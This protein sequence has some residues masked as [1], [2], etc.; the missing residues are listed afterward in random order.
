MGIQKDV[1]VWST[2]DLSSLPVS[3]GNTFTV[4]GTPDPLAF[5]DDI[6]TEDT[7]D[8]RPS[9]FPPEDFDQDL[10]GTLDGAQFWGNTGNQSDTFEFEAAYKVTDGTNTFNVYQIHNVSG[11]T[12]GYVSEQVLDPNAT[13]QVLEVDASVNDDVGDFPSEPYWSDLAGQVDGTS[14]GEVIGAGYVDD[15][16]DGVNEGAGQNDVI[17]GEGGGDTIEAGAGGDLIY[18]DYVEE[19]PADASDYVIQGYV[20]DFNFEMTAGDLE[21]SPTTATIEVSGAPVDIRFVDNDPGLGGDNV[22]D[23]TPADSDQMVEINGVLYSYSADH[24]TEFLG[25]DG[26]TYKMI[27]I[28]VDRDRSGAIDGYDASTDAGDVSYENGQILLPIG[29]VPPPGTTLSPTGADVVDASDPD[30]ISINGEALIPGHDDSISGGADNDTVYGGMGADTIDGGTED[31]SITGGTGAD[32]ITGGDG[33]DQF[34]Y[35]AGDGADTITDFNTGN[36][37]A[38][39]DGDTSNNDYIDLSGF[40]NDTT[41]AEVNALGIDEFGGNLNMLKA[42]AEDG[43]LDGIINGT[44]YSS[45]ISGI[46]LT[47]QNGGA[48]VTGSDLTA[49]NTRVTC[50][51]RGTMIMTEH[52]ERPIETLHQG[53]MILTMDSGYQPIR[54]IG[55]THVSEE[56]LR[57]N[58]NLRPIRIPA[59]ALGNNIPLHDLIV[60]PQHRILIR[61]KIARRMFNRNEVLIA[62]KHLLNGGAIAIANDLKSTQYFHILFDKH[63]LVFSNNAVTESMYTGPEALKSVSAKARHEIITLFPELMDIDYVSFKC[64]EFAGGHQAHRLAARH[65]DNCQM[66]FES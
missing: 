21:T 40:Y 56:T 14:A 36:T 42:D 61:S 22:T 16:N 48:S 33:N 19:I 13:Y 32:S 26:I 23:E 31:D 12:S 39:D 58:D 49:D 50:F 57:E 62:A 5:K 38:L 63:E 46:D 11:G 25:S 9:D 35:A 1:L 65:H 60:S 54:W 8:T 28:D 24:E 27:V 52:G 6:D 64:R 29:A 17:L 18:G 55:A 4:T 43:K 53:D 66:F 41:L 37:G 45:I 51:T 7:V 30:Y 34:S 15:D 2:T 44:D 20:R 47:L 3:V 10:S 59:G